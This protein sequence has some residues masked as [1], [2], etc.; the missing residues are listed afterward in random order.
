MNVEC[1]ERLQE[2]MGARAATSP[3]ER[4]LYSRDLAPVPEV[5]VNPMFKTVPDILVQP[6]DAGEAAAVMKLA[7][8]YGIPVTPRAGGS[9]VYFDSVPLKSGIVMDLNRLKGVVECNQEAMLVRVKAGTTWV[10]LDEYLQPRGLTLKSYP[11]SAPAASIGGWFSMMGYGIGSLKYG[12]LQ[13]QIH[14][15]EVVFPNGEIR[16]LDRSSEPSLDQFASSE[17]TLG[18]ITELELEVRPITEIRHFL[19]QSDSATTMMEA[20]HY[21]TY[22]QPIPYNLHFSGSTYNIQMQQLGFAAEEEA[23]MCCALVSY[24]GSS[25]ELKK[26]AQI[27]DKIQKEIPGLLLMAQHLAEQEWEERF[28]ALRLKRGGPSQLGAEIWLPLDKLDAYLKDIEKMDQSYRLGLA[29]YGHVV[30][31]THMTMMTMFYTNEVR[32]VDYIMGLSLV[33]KI[34][35]IGY[36]HGGYP[37]GVGL[38]NTPYL[39]RIYSAD[40]LAEMRKRK[41]SIDPQGIMNPGKVYHWPVLLNPFNFS[42][43][44]TFLS[45]IKLLTGRGQAK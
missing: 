2:L 26:A 22:H 4:R 45:A 7:G 37:Y 31:P 28:R 33:K 39:G 18:I 42:F 12:S 32:T 36:K 13:L 34:H 19:L 14:S 41:R 25:A 27:V 20:I 17:G 16:N 1:L 44:C 40:K 21:F 30:G 6:L 29:S 8:E 38:W 24:E 35:D 11:S 23:G 3:F 9:T 5:M 43:G 15:I 10:E